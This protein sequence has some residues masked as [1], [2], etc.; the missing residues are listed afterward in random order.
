MPT[1]LPDHLSLL[2]VSRR[3]SALDVSPRGV[4]RAAMPVTRQVVWMT[5]RAREVVGPKA[6]TTAADVEVQTIASLAQHF[7]HRGLAG[8]ER[9][10]EE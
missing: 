3:S 2:R 7:A 6:V 5:R 8:V 1:L 10:R 4:R 9:R